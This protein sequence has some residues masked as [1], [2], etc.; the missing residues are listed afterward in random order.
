[1]RARVEQAY[2]L[3]CDAFAGNPAIVVSLDELV[4]DGQ[5]LAQV[6]NGAPGRRAGG[7]QPRTETRSGPPSSRRTGPIPAPGMRPMRRHRVA[8]RTCRA[9]DFRPAE[10]CGG[11]PPARLAGRVGVTRPAMAPGADTMLAARLAPMLG[12]Q[13]RET[14]DSPFGIVALFDS[15][16]DSQALEPDLAAIET[17]ERGALITAPSDEADFAPPRLPLKLGL[18]EDPSAAR[19]IAFPRPIGGGS[20]V[21]TS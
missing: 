7:P 3:R 5:M 8:H 6:C 21:A 19:P 17:L 14:P 18:P 11:W 15:A 12:R 4:P 10:R 9:V 2:D 16:S 1:M 20:S 13:P